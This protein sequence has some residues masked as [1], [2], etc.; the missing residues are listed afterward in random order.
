[1]SEVVSESGGPSFHFSHIFLQTVLARI[2][3]SGV[4]AFSHMR[5]ASSA[6]TPDSKLRCK[7]VKTLKDGERRSRMGSNSGVMGG[8]S[9]INVD[10]C[11]DRRSFSLNNAQGN[12][13]SP[14]V[15]V[16]LLRV[17]LTIDW[18]WCALKLYA[19]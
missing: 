19:I 5:A 14:W 3:G 16:L 13:C 8:G 17:H 10:S 1:M 9:L 2:K 4:I 11:L 18:I 15:P 6:C 7:V 12:K